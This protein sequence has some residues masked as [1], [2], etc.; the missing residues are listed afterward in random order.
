MPSLRPVRRFHSV[1]FGLSLSWFSI[2]FLVIYI[3]WIMDL[4][5]INHVMH[6]YFNSVRPRLV[7]TPVPGLIRSGGVTQ[8]QMVPVSRSNAA[9]ESFHNFN[10][11]YQVL[12]TQPLKFITPDSSPPLISCRIGRSLI[13]T[14]FHIRY[15]IGPLFHVIIIFTSIFL[16]KNKKVSQ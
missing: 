8:R 11:S 7:H 14:L 4:G 13:L 16:N 15:A 9:N 12:T 2:L 6:I 1:Y 3:P 10:S 5:L